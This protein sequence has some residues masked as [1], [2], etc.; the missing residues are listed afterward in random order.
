MIDLNPKSL[1]R[2][3][4]AMLRKLSGYIEDDFYEGAISRLFTSCTDATSIDKSLGIEKYWLVDIDT[5]DVSLMHLLRTIIKV[6][7]PNNG[8]EKCKIVLD[9]KN[10]YHL[11]TTPFNLEEF[12]KNKNLYE[13]EFFK[14]ME[15]KKDCLTNLYIP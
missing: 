7:S 13:D 12:N 15:V 8:D 14:N 11:I 10:G 5:K 4:H 2:V 1:K 6:C 9:S 3:T